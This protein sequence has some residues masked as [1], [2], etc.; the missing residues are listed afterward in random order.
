MKTQCILENTLLVTNS[1]T[2]KDVIQST[3]NSN[4]KLF[5][6]SRIIYDNTKKWKIEHKSNPN[7]LSNLQISNYG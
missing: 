4:I 1:I 2:C 5:K 3:T 6:V 7:A